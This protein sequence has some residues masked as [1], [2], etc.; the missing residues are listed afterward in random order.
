MQGLL[1]QKISGAK[2]DYARDAVE[3]ADALI[4][5]LNEEKT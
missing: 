4:A 5:A 1:S 3:C 2:A